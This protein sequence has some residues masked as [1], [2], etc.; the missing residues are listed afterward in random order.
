MAREHATAKAV[1]GWVEKVRKIVAEQF[2]RDPSPF[3]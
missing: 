1:E 3:D 2:L